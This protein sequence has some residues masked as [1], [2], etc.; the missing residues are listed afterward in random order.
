MYERQGKIEAAFHAAGVPADTPIRGFNE[1]N[2]LK[3]LLAAHLAIGTRQTMQRRL[4]S[5]VLAR[6][7]QRIEGSLLECGSDRRPNVPALSRDVV[8]CDTRGTAREW[9]QGRQDKNRR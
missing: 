5:H 2:A 6:T 7:Q 8:A 3:Q 9:Q 1:T 4:K